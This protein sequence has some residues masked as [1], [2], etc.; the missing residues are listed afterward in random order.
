[1]TTTFLVLL[2][3]VACLTCMVL[4]FYS[5]TTPVAEICG[6]MQNDDAFERSVYLKDP[7]FKSGQTVNVY[8][9][10]AL[11]TGTFEKHVRDIVTE[12]VAPYVNLKLNFI[13]T[14]TP[15]ASGALIT[16]TNDPS[17]LSSSTVSGMTST[18]NKNKMQKAII[19]RDGTPKRTVI[20]E[21]GHALGLQ[22]EQYHPDFKVKLDLN[23]L[24]ERRM[25]GNPNL[26][27]EVATKD[28]ISQNF[29]KL[30]ENV[31]GY[32]P[33]YDKDSV[34][35]YSYAANVTTDGVKIVGGQEF[36]IM[37]KAQ[38]RRMYP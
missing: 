5:T 21:F 23:A 18:I 22:H 37:D 13:N 33:L 1:M 12:Y 38:L 14:Q 3:I 17:R 20:H 19:I 28:V 6:V 35:L 24:V 34:M 10:D 26:S 36:S 30:D 16:V 29:R 11:G 25:A 32:T 8:T 31:T 9:T 2:F 7:P 27:R 4:Y 15:S